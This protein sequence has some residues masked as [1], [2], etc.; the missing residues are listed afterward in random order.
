[1]KSEET[2]RRTLKRKRSISKL[3]IYTILIM[4]ILLFAFTAV[5][6]WI[7]KD[8]TPLTVIIPCIFTEMGVV[9]AFYMWKSK[10][11]SVIE[12][13]VK[14]GEQFIENTLDDV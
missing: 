7:T 5:M 4:T 3:L 2:K 9:S 12:L 10:V 1:M 13:K 8:L 11:L 14:Y 6:T